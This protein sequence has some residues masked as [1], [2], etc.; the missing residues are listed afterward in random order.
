M[1]VLKENTVN[2]LEIGASN[3]LAVLVDIDAVAQAC[4]SSMEGQLGEMQ[5]DVS[6]GIPT[7]ATI[8]GGVPNLP[9]FEFFA[10]RTLEAVEGVTGIAGFSVKLSGERAAY[11][12]AINT[13]F[14]PTNVEG[15][16]G[17]V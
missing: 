17:A 8:W 4:T 11:S 12:A 9:Q 14:G 10:R 2:D 13:I 3:Q 5:Y 16:I 6:R 1:R 7:D 15:I